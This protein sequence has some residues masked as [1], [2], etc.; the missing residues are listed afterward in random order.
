MGMSSEDGIV[1]RRRFI[2]DAL[3]SAGLVIA[4]GIVDS[5]ARLDPAGL[6]G[7]LPAKVAAVEETVHAHA[8][9]FPTTPA[10][11]A[12]PTLLRDYIDARHVA[13]ES[14]VDQHPI[15]YGSLAYLAAFLAAQLA[16]QQDYDSAHAWYG[17]AM[18]HADYV[19]D[20]EALGWIAG[21]AA[22]M[23]WYQHD[24][25]Q[26]VHDAA[27]AAVHSPAGQLGTTLGTR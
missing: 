25:R 26:T 20:S 11:D 13:R 10:V 17:I 18:E 8:M 15:A 23:P 12:L 4:P 6:P 7:T 5:A 2:R 22:L 21:R 3:T 14:R 24:A 19:G 16:D 1:R 27:Y 9:A